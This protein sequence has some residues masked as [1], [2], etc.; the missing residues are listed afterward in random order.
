MVDPIP[1]T[2]GTEERFRNIG[3]NS[4]SVEFPKYSFGSISVTE[5]LPHP[6]PPVTEHWG[7]AGPE[8]TEDG[9]V[10]VWA[11]LTSAIPLYENNSD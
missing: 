8:R 2:A 1:G 4:S 6:A 5:L 11:E 10:G 3:T 9:S 7:T